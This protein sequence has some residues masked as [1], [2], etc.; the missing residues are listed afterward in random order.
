M[1]YFMENSKDNNYTLFVRKNDSVPV[2]VHFIGYDR[3]FGSHYD[4]YVIIYSDFDNSVPDPKVF[5]YEKRKFTLHVYT[6]IASLQ[7]YKV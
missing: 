6:V 2:L 5:D 4:E 3:L 7:L 1:S